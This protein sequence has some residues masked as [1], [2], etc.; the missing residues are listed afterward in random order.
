M[1]RKKIKSFFRGFYIT[2]LALA[3]LLLVTLG[4][5]VAQ[6]NTQRIGYGL[7]NGGG[8]REGTLPIACIFPEIMA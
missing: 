5:Q 8:P 3:M 4:T 7:S 6:E 1:D 2:A